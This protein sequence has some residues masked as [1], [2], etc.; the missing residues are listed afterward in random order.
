MGEKFW[1]GT[2]KIICEPRKLSSAI[3]GVDELRDRV[4]T[5]RYMTLL[6]QIVCAKTNIY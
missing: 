4:D 1:R 6:Q 2:L 3:E 5:I